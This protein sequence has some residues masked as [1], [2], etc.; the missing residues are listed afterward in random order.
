MRGVRRRLGVMAADPGPVGRAAGGQAGGGSASASG[1]TGARAHSIVL[2]SARESSR[3]LAGGTHH[4]R[5]HL[6]G[7]GTLAGAVAAAHL[8][9]DHR[10]DGWPAPPPVGGVYRR[11]AQEEEHRREL[12]GQVLGEALGGGHGGAVSIRRRAGRPVGRAPSPDRAR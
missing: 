6:L 3:A 8:A 1:T 2:N 7:V 5:Q 11:V 10:R 4:A 9:G 12:V